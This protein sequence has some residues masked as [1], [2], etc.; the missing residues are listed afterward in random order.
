[1]LRTGGGQSILTHV[2]RK[3]VPFYENA[4]LVEWWLVPIFDEPCEISGTGPIS[5][6]VPLTSL[7]CQNLT[8]I[9][10]MN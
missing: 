3:T 7:C 8:H 1:M 9:V 2:Q 5:T 4:D 10:Y 6:L